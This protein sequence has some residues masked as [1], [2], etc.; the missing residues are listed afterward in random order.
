MD[1]YYHNH[2]RNDNEILDSYNDIMGGSN[3]SSFRSQKMAVFRT[4]FFECL[5]LLVIP[6]PFFDSYIFIQAKKETCCYLLSE[7][8]Y[9]FMWYRIYYLFR[10][11][12]DQSIYMDAISKKTCNQ[13]NIETGV[14][15]I[16][17][18]WINM[19][20]SKTMLT[21][22]FTT[23]FL[24]AYLLRLAELPFYRKLGMEHYFFNSVWMAV[25]TLTTVGGYGGDV[26]TVTVPG[27]FLT[28]VMA[29]SGTVMLSLVVVG[30]SG[31]FKLDNNQMMAIRDINLKRAAAGT[32][33]ASLEYFK[34]KRDARL[35][36]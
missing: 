32:I 15:F 29:V 23:V 4:K 11:F 6:I 26:S 13:Y 14:K 16:V 36:R 5:L 10:Y 8:L 1:L 34:A 28:M 22:F 3:T 27:R 30:L 35:L 7:V 9:G 19:N 25:I 20:P 24:A 21:F 12:V 18:T 33:R 2:H 31:F 17:Q